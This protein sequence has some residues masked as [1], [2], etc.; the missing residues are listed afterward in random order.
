MPERFT[1]RIRRKWT[2]FRVKALRCIFKFAIERYDK[3]SGGAFMAYSWGVDDV[4][5]YNVIAERSYPD[6]H[7]YGTEVTWYDEELPKE[8][9]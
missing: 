4:T 3:L 7:V 2:E 1:D 5:D 8:E 6:H 9:S